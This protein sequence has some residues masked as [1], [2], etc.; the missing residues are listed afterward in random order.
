MDVHSLFDLS[1]KVAIVT[2]G[3]VGIGKGNCALFCRTRIAMGRR[4]DSFCQWC[5]RAD[6]RLTMHSAFTQ[7]KVEPANK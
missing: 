2:G 1:G 5:W 4:I 6:A 7:S 3:G